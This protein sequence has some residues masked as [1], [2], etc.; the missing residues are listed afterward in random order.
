MPPDT[1]A[2]D[3]G[4]GLPTELGVRPDRV[5]VAPPAGEFSPGMGRRGEERLVGALVP[6]SAIEALGERVLRRLARR[7]VVP[8]DPMFRI[9]PASDALAW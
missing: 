1:L 3:L 5:V 7:D 8:P 4:G 2:G 6:Q 9:R